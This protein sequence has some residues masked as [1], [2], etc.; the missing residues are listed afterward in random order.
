VTDETQLKLFGLLDLAER[1]QAELTAAIEAL[2]AERA[3]LRD[4]LAATVRQP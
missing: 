1:Q 2:K 4:E 3:A